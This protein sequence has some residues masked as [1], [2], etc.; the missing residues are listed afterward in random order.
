[1]HSVNVVVLA[2]TV[3]TS[4]VERRMS[5]GDTVT[6]LRVSAPGAEEQRLLPLPVVISHKT[7]GA[8]E[9]EKIREIGKGDVVLLHG[10]LVRRFYRSGAGARTL[11]EVVA[12][13]IK[14]QGPPVDEDGHIPDESET[15]GVSI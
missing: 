11:T 10:E 3:A 14:K 7:V 9:L 1:M 2:G 8:D 4:P 5:D 13:S 12:G 6:E 15:T